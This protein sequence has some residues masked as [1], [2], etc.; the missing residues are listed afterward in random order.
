MA[1]PN[2]LSRETAVALDAARAASALI[3]RIYETPFEVEWKGKGDPVTVAD[4]SANELLVAA[5]AAAFPDDHICAEEADAAV[6]ASAS[7]KGGRCWF[8][9][10]L[11]G[12]RE[13][14]D[15]NGEF[16]VM[17]GL[18]VGGEARLGV[19]V[20]PAWRRTLVGVVG[21]GAWEIT[22]AGERA[23]TVS[24]PSQVSQASLAVSR[25]HPHPRVAS[26]AARLG[27]TAM[28]PCGSVGLKVALVATGAVSAYVHM[29]RGPKLWDGCAPEA[30]ARAAGAEVTDAAGRGLRYDTSELA[31]SEGIVVA[32]AGLAATLREALAADERAR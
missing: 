31:L 9:D 15:R 28:R 18:A 17:V 11:D 10:P 24:P 13:F 14:V 30:I 6:A 26:M 32:P 5:L 20:A 2:P 16:C 21:H 27:I 29:G 22:D 12:T 25:S 4:R 3:E 23:L 1:N 8:V 19:I 7:A